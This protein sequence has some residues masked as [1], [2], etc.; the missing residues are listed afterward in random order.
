MKKK[1]NTKKQADG[2]NKILWMAN[3]H[4]Y[5]YLPVLVLVSLIWKSNTL[6]CMGAGFLLF[7][8]YTFIGF[9]CRW[10]HIYCSFQSMQ[11]QRM[12]PGNVNWNTILLSTVY[13][14]PTAFGIL[15][16]VMVIYQVFY[17]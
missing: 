12:T 7:A 16:L 15:G 11:K 13:K 6:L 17:L 10:T 4:R 8:V 2:S 9:K 1:E 5:L 14:M 3:I